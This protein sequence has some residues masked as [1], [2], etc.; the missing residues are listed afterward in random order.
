MRKKNEQNQPFIIAVSGKARSGKGEFAK[1]AQEKYGA[2]VISFA[3]ALKEEVIDFLTRHSIPFRMENIYGANEFREELFSFTES[4]WFDMEFPSTKFMLEVGEI[5]NPSSLDNCPLW[6]AS[7][8]S[9][10]QW[11]GTEYRRKQDDQYWV[12]KAIEKC[13]PNLFQGGGSPLYVIDDL[14]FENEATALLSAGAILVRVERTNN[15]NSISNPWHESETG[16]DSWLEWKYII[17]N[18]SSLNEYHACCELVLDEI[19]KE[20]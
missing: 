18:N 17:E 11:W 5:S 3:G 6:K 16:L 8:R 20:E 15:P 14:R 13:K 10:L 12:N 9:L 2:T 7:F 4:A 1:I 19:L